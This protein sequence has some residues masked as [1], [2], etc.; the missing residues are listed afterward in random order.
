MLLGDCA[1]S[2]LN[3]NPF[4]SM[5]INAYVK[6]LGIHFTYDYRIRQKMNFDGLIISIKD[7]L[8]IWMWTDL[9]IIGRI[10]IVKTFIIPIFLYRASMICL[11][12]E[13]VNG[14]NKIIFNFIWKG[15]DKI[16]RLALI[17]DIEDGGLK[18]PHLDSVIKTQRILVAN[19]SQVSNPAVGKLY[20]CIISNLLEV[21][22]S[23]VATLM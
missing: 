22:L 3:H 13:F 9:I 11:D 2:S 10:Q 17:S 4:K 1:Y 12:K 16:K 5:K 6:I 23:Y 8:R 21:K 20:F 14:V 15:K 18:A 7:K 19:D